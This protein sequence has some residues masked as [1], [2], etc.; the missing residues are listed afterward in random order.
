LPSLE[1]CYKPIDISFLE[2]ASILEQDDFKNEIALEERID[3]MIDR[4]VK[5]L[6]QIKAMKQ[7]LSPPPPQT[8]KQPRQKNPEQ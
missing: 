1:R 3:A 8:E 4:L 2:A 7:M 5:R 6:V